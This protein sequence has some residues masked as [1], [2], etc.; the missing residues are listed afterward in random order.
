MNKSAP[1]IILLSL[2]FTSCGTKQVT[3]SAAVDQEKLEQI[4]KL[5]TEQAQQSQGGSSTGGTVSTDPLDPRAYVSLTARPGKFEIIEG[6]VDDSLRV[7]ATQRNGDER[8]LSKD[9]SFEIE[10]S[11]LLEIM[12]DPDSARFDI[13]AIKPGKTKVVAQYGSLSIE[14]P[15]EIKARQ[16]QSLEIVPKAIS[17]GVPTRFRLS[18]NYD[19]LTQADI[20]DGVVWQ[21]NSSASL[22]GATGSSGSGIFTGLKVGSVGLKADYQG[23]SIVSRTQIQMPAIR[24]IAVTADSTTF[25]LGTYAPVQAIATFNNNNSF[26]ITSSVSWS[27]NDTS[28]GTVNSQGMLEALYPGE[29]VVRAQYGDVQGEETFSVSSVNFKSFRIEPTSA[30]FPLGMNQ[31][32][33]LYGVLANNSEQEITAYARW[34]SSNDQIAKAGGLDEPSVRGLYAAIQKGSAIVY[35][36]YGSTTLQAPITI[37]D[38]A[39]A[40]LSI[41]SDNPEG[42]CGV[43]NPQFTAEGLLSD[44]SSKDMTAAV[45][46]SVDPSDAAI[47]SADPNHRGLILTKKAG[48]ATVTASYLEPATNQLIKATSVITIQAPVVTGVGITAALSSLA[49]GQSVQMQAG[50]IM[51]CGTGADYT[52]QVTWSSN[53]TNLVTLS[54]T[55]GSKGLLTTKGSTTTPT[56]VSITAVGGGFN[57]TF[58]MEIRPKEVETIAV[59]PGKTSLVVGADSTSLTVN[60]SFTDGTVENM[61]NISNYTGYG[62]QYYL[63]DCPAT[64]CGTIQGSNGLITAGT[65][66]GLIRPRAVLTT[67]TGKLIISPNASV[68]V[69]SKCTG[70]GKLSGYYC[71]FL[72]SKGASCDQTCSAT[73]RTYHPATLSTYGSGGDPIEC[74]NALYDLG[75]IKKLETDKFNHGEGL[76]CSI[77]TIPALN[78]QQSVRETA[79]PTNATDSNVDF[80]R[81]CACRET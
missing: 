46:W 72:S 36:R 13:K 61:T 12:D 62:L 27:V 43:N 35:A 50:Q 75:Y 60:A 66:E 23:M 64:G 18:A 1:I 21:S 16:I 63:A 32:F 70:S 34:T 57:G 5:I 53:N 20:T 55:S 29:L 17:L 15:I 6:L 67:P 40:S 47:P 80:Q 2:W 56:T 44:N 19:N 24:S 7:I 41:K 33:K 59:V 78:I 74:G 30:S 77:W 10:D 8:T 79:T 39:L 9:V 4:K 51:S 52:N 11:S 37:T 58:D 48:T 14:F 68:K 3:Q 54:N 42:A 71:V 26:D 65:V 69:V 49:I 38:A 76:G 28:I 81:V 22:Q 25:L 73:G 31:N 45:T